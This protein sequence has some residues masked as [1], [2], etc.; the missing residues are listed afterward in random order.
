MKK[1]N[2]IAGNCV[3]ESE[4]ISLETAEFLVKMSE[5]YDFNLIYKSSFKKDNRTS[6]KYFSGLSIEESIRIF[7]K[8]KDEFNLTLLTD[9]H[10]LYEFDTDLVKIIDVFQLPAFLCMQTELTKRMASF[11]KPINIKKGQFLAPLD[12][13][14]IIEKIRRCGNDKIMITERGTMFG[15]HDLVVDPRSIYE[16]KQF[17]FPVYFDAGHT[18]RRYGIPSHSIQGGMKHYVPTLSKAM[19]A[20]GADGIFVECHPC[21]MY[22]RCDNATQLSFSE[23]EKLIQAVKPI[24]DALHFC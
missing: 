16:L 4:N 14:H 8:L 24:W 5:K 20:A 15:Y 12:V 22:A 9:F 11:K 17:G 1:L 18:V 2:I 7:E 3:L 6:L 23:F 10:N 21:P 13:G 19:I